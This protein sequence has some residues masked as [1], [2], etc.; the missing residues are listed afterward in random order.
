ME[1]GPGTELNGGRL[2]C[3]K[4]DMGGAESEDTVRAGRTV[5]LCREQR[6]GCPD[7]SGPPGMRGRGLYPSQGWCPVDVFQGQLPH[8][9]LWDPLVCQ[10]AG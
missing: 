10:A 5:M 3:V 4:E 8:M 6:S 2:S 7:H 1:P 9:R